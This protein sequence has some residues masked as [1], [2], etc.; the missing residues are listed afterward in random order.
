MLVINLFTEKKVAKA[1]SLVSNPICSPSLNLQVQESCGSAR[2]STL[3]FNQ[4]AGRDL[5][6]ISKV[7]KPER[8]C[9]T[10]CFIFLS[11]LLTLKSKLWTRALNNLV[12]TFWGLM[13][14]FSMMRYF[15][16][17]QNPLLCH[18]NEPVWNLWSSLYC[19]YCDITSTFHPKK[20]AESWLSAPGFESEAWS[21]QLSASAFSTFYCFS[22]HWMWIAHKTP[23]KQ[24]ASSKPK[25]VPIAVNAGR[26]KFSWKI[27]VLVFCYISFSWIRQKKGEKLKSLGCKNAFSQVLSLTDSSVPATEVLMIFWP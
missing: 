6:I 4:A 22:Q 5:C 24:Q 19:C 15:V 8:K 18:L 12:G 7:W 27:P 13:Q 14:L 26:N 9:V 11:N 16:R 21:I 10:L 20:L 1:Y 25:H 3:T 23:C 2:L 17:L